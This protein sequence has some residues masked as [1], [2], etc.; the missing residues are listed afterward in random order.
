VI[1]KDR[2]VGESLLEFIPCS[3]SAIPRRHLI[4]KVSK[5][6]RKFVES[7]RMFAPEGK[8]TYQLK[9]F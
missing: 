8:T 5:E 7:R 6:L 4:L 1:T 2:K 3:L 9:S